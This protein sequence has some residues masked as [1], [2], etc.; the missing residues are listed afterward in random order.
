M[1]NKRIISASIDEDL[2]SE[3][4]EAASEAD[5]SLSEWIEDRITDSAEVSDSPTAEEVLNMDWNEKI[6]VTDEYGL[7]VDSDDYDGNDDEF[8]EAVIDELGL[9]YP[10]D[11]ENPGPMWLLLI[12]VVGFFAW[13][14]LRK[15]EPSV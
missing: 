6:D 13:L 12:P 14:I 9:E 4:R 8:A 5:M 1:G 7:D 3:V 15:S 11:D 10:L 2:Y